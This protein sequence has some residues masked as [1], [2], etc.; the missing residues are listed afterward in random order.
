M[1]FRKQTPPPRVDA[2]RLAALAGKAQA[3]PQGAPVAAASADSAE[4][5]RG[6]SDRGSDNAAAPRA[7]VSL[8]PDLSRINKNRSGESPAERKKRLAAKSV[9]FSASFLARAAI[10]GAAIWYGYEGYRATGDID[11]LVAV[12]ILAMAADFGRVLIK[13]MQP[14]GR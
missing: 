3:A 4:N 11:R 6:V 7:R 12:A 14:G 10:L 13:S 5:D 1:A 8:E 2:G 9:N